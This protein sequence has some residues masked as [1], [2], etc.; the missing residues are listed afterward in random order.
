MT[1]TL[2]N[3]CARNICKRTPLVQFI[4]KN[5]VT[6]FLEH[7]VETPVDPRGSRMMPPPGRQI[8]LLHRVILTFELLTSK[9][10]PEMTYNASSGRLN[11]TVLYRGLAAWITCAHWH[12]NVLNHFQNILYTILVRKMD[13]W[14]TR[15]HN[16]G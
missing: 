2:G 7:S 1:Y 13:E 5:V 3:T 8:Y 16:T 10:V 15:E 4:I 11:P 6:C 14:S 9:I 12:E